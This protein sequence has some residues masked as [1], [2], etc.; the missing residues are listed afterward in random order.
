METG[1]MLE[2]LRQ[3]TSLPS[4]KPPSLN[5]AGPVDPAEG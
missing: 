2:Y 5:G 1:L 3:P 4:G